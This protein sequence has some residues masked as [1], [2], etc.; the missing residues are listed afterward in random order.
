M[1]LP[2]AAAYILV[3]TLVAPALVEMGV[4]LMAAHLFVFYGAM[5]SS[6]TPPV[7]LAAYAAA[8]LANENPM[9]IAMTAVCFGAA[10]FLVPFFFVYDPALIGI[11]SLTDVAW[12]LLTALLG[13]LCIASSVQGWLLARVGWVGRS[14][15]GI[16]S[17]LLISPS[18]SADLVGAALLLAV[19]VL[20][21]SHRARV[22]E[23]A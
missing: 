17:I 4:E 1:G 23:P 6:I 22:A 2:T 16:A 19:L 20:Q 3:A 9:K 7:A 12:A 10:A 13:A 11:G 18:L 14:G 5:L 8:G 21:R 15:L